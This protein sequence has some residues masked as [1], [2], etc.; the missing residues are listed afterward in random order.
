M[1]VLH[2]ITGLAAGG[3]EQQLRSLLPHLG[4]RSEV[5]VLT[6]RGVV[7]DAIERTGVPVH[8]AGMR[9]NR[10]L[11][12]VGRLAR[13]M[14]S[15]RYDVVHTHLYRACVYGRLAARLAN[16]PAIVATEHSIGCE[17]I[18]GRRLTHP[19]RALYLAS[20]RLG[21]LTVAVSPSVADRL[22]RWGVHRSRIV[23]IP[24]GVDGTAF[25]FDAALR[26]RTRKRLGLADDAFVIGGVGRLEPG[27]RFDLLVEAM[28]SLEPAVLLLVGSGSCEPRLRELARAAGADRRVIFA[29]ESLDVRAMLSAMDVLAAPSAEETFG[30]AVVEALACGLP[31]LYDTCPAIDDLPP[32]SAPG[33]RRVAPDRLA[34]EL[35]ALVARPPGRLAPPDALRLYEIRRQAGQL[36][37]LYLRLLGAVPTEEYR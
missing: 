26:R 10:D 2:V 20:E 6:G 13:L 33:A 12:A 17:H 22:A 29:G 5:A 9:G 37:S 36:E 24:N 3:A 27:K 18:E 28:P 30:L 19:I 15:R 35:S 25:G 7:A 11:R 14:R 23:V 21:H 31:V 4:V 32:G 16:V 1:K 8:Y 34:A